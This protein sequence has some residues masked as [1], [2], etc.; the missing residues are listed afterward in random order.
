MDIG[1]VM[2]NKRI[3]PSTCNKLML[4]CLLGYHFFLKRSFLFLDVNAWILCVY[5]TKSALLFIQCEMC[6]FVILENLVALN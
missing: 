3:L 1:S 6:G 2:N 4:G 5:I